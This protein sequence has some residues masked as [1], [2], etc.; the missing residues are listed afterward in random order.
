M[1]DHMWKNIELKKRVLTGSHSADRERGTWFFVFFLFTRVPSSTEVKTEVIF[2]K[3]DVTFCWKG[4]G[5]WKWTL[6]RKLG[7]QMLVGW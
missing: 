7:R 6:Q 4:T 3:R 5:K 1:L 2:E